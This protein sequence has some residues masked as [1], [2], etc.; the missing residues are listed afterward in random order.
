MKVGI[1]VKYAVTVSGGVVEGAC[2][3]VEGGKISYVGAEDLAPECDKVYEYEHG[4]AIPGLVN[5]HNHLFQNLLKNWGIDLELLDWLSTAIWPVVPK[6]TR[7]EMRIG[8]LLGITENV[9]SGVTTI[10]DM[11]YGNPHFDVVADAMVEAGIRG[12]IS[13]GFYEI[14]A[15]EELRERLDRVLENMDDLY[16]EYKGKVGIMPGPMHPCF[17][18]N[19]SLVELHRWAKD[20]GTRY[21]THLAESERDVQLLVR[22]EG[23]RD[24]ELMH[25]L[26]ILDRDFIGVHSVN[27]TPREVSLMGQAGATA[28]H[29]PLSNLYVADGI[30]PIVALKRAGANISMA[31]DG[32]ASNGRLDMFAEMKVAT[33]LQKVAAGDVTAFKAKDALEAATLGGAR[34]LGLEDEI[35]SLEEGK[36]ADIVVL[37]M[38]SLAG[39]LSHDPVGYV[40]YSASPEDVRLVM[41]EGRVLYEDG[42]FKTID[43]KAI[44]REARELRIGR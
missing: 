7:E 39:T 27:L 40:V 21:Y 16:E 8:A 30:A 12:F 26:G 6:L 34:A 18:S 31:T 10:V 17:V 28:V 36:V 25:K 20:R 29:C 23:L 38:G 32:A 43:I 5:M 41:S 35:G 11:H 14:E 24:A 33:V 2:I 44:L 9:K 3:V 4:V 42:Q 37:D 19:E 22:R 15:R 1:R 13:R